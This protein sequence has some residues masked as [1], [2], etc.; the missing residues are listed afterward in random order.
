MAVYS[1]D[2]L[3]LGELE[4]G[5]KSIAGPLSPVPGRC[6]FALPLI[7]AIKGFCFL[8]LIVVLGSYVRDL[9][10]FPVLRLM[11]VGWRYVAIGDIKENYGRCIVGPLSPVPRGFIVFFFESCFLISPL[12]IVCAFL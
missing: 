12:T 2:R 3:H 1:G 11:A 6:E 5:G 9:S 7:F 4:T 10:E 8:K